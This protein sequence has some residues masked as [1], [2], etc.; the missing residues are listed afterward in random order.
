MQLTVKLFA[1]FR[2][3]RFAVA[4]KTYPETATVGDIIADLGI[5][6]GEV[7]VTMLNSK[8]CQLTTQ[9]SD[10]DILAIFPVIG[11]G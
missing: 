9:P 1:T 3:N 10:G 2:E 5:D 11:G 7:G 8:H 6:A 4:E